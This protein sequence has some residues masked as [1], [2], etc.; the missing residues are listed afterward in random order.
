M[1]TCKGYALCANAHIFRRP[2][3]TCQVHACANSEIHAHFGDP[4]AGGNKEMSSVFADQEPP[5]IRVQMRGDWGSCGVSDNK[6]SCVHHVTW[7]PNKL[8]RS[9]SL[10]NLCPQGTLTVHMRR[11][12][13]AHLPW[14][15]AIR[16]LLK[17]LHD[18]H[19]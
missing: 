13:D 1:T 17:N 4:Q 10:F 12:Q 7:S 19:V 6:Y 2:A 5:R 16:D 11:R 18:A 3:G 14:R 15:P 8:L 9:T